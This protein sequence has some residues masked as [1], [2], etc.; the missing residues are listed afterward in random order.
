MHTCIVMAARCHMTWC[1]VQRSWACRARCSAVSIFLWVVTSSLTSCLPPMWRIKQSRGLKGP[2]VI[3]K[4]LVH[5]TLQP[6]LGTGYANSAPCEVQGV[7]FVSQLL[8]HAQAKNLPMIECSPPY[9]PWRGLRW[10]RRGSINFISHT[11]S[12]VLITDEI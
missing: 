9:Q 11:W 1:Q 6:L 3:W 12:R 4:L 2:S 10:L 5:I 8:W 7:R